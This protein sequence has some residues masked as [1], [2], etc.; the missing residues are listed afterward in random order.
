MGFFLPPAALQQTAVVG[1]RRD[2]VRRE[3]LVDGE[4]DPAEHRARIVLARALTRFVRH[5]VVVC[6]DEQLRVAFEPDDGELS[7]RDKQ[8]LA[9]AGQHQRLVEA[10]QQRLR[11]GGRGF[12]LAAAVAIDPS[13]ILESET[14][15]IDVDD[16]YGYG[17]GQTMGFRGAAPEGA[18][19]AKI[20]YAVDRAKIW[21]MVEDVFNKL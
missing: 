10:A 6:R 7:N 21:K 8:A 12:V 9:F 14:L 13:V 11:D 15:P 2:A 1:V 5:A 4:V 16:Q 17:Y 18:Q 20:V 3:E 19:N